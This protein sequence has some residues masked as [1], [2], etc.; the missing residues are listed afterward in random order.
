MELSTGQTSALNRVVAFLQD[1]DVPT[2]RVDPQAGLVETQWLPPMNIKRK[3]GFWRWLAGQFHDPDK[4][5]A[6]KF[7]FTV[8]SN[9]ATGNAEIRVQQ[10]K[11]KSPEPDRAV[12]WPVKNQDALVV[13]AMFDRLMDYFG[14]QGNQVGSVVLSKDVSTLPE[15][16]MT[17]DGNGF[18][19]LVINRDFNQAWQLVGAALKAANLPILDLDRSLGVYYLSAKN[20]KVAGFDAEMESDQDVQV[21]LANSESGVQVSV[22]LDDETVAPKNLSAGI[23]NRL[24]EHLP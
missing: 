19:I 5:S 14:E 22:Q 20:L 24:R 3:R 10:A 2:S 6:E 11:A 17:W 4:N 1:S 21:R 9:Q 13:G 12:A 8:S 16:T 15:Y 23:L 7:L 18:P